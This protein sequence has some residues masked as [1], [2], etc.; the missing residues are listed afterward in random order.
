MQKVE[1]YYSMLQ[2]KR[3]MDNYIQ[4]GWRVHTCTMGAYMAGYTCHE[5]V[6][7]IYEK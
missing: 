7:V 6:L 3:G 2:A 1:M 4:S 5:V